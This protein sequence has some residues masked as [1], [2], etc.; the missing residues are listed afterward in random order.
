MGGQFHNGSLYQSIPLGHINTVPT[1]VRAFIK[2]NISALTGKTLQDATL[3]L[4]RNVSFDVAGPAVHQIGVKLVDYDAG[5]GA[6]AN[7]PSLIGRSVSVAG[8]VRISNE[9]SWFSVNVTEAVQAAIA[10]GYS[11]ITLR[12]NDDTADASSLAPAYVFLTTNPT[13]TVTEAPAIPVGNVATHIAWDYHAGGQ[14][15]NGAWNGVVPVGNINSMPTGVRAFVKFDI[16]AFAGRTLSAATLTLP[17]AA[18][19]AVTGTHNVGVSLVGHDAGGGVFANSPPW[20]TYGITAGTTVNVSNAATSYSLN[21]TPIIQE[22]INRGY[23]YA[24]IRLNDNTAEAGSAA[25]SY[26]FFATNPTLSLAEPAMTLVENGV[27]R[28][29]IHNMATGTPDIVEIYAATQLQAAI[30]CATGVTPAIN[31]PTPAPIKIN[32]GVATQFASGVGNANEQAYTYRR[33]GSNVVELVANKPAGVLWAVDDFSREILD[34]MWPLADDQITRGGSLQPTLKINPLTKVTWPDFPRRGWIIAD[35]TDG[36]H[37]NDL[38][39]NWMARTRQNV[40]FNPVSQLN[41][42]R[43][44]KL[45]HGI[46]P[47]T[48]MHSFWWLVPE[49]EYFDTHP[50]Y[51]P[52][53]GGVR[54]RPDSPS[55]LYVQLC[56]S[57]P[58]VLQI[59]VN[60]ALAS[61]AAFPEMQIFGVCQNDGSG[62]WC[63]C[64]NCQAWDG[65]QAGTGKYSNRLIHFVNLVAQGIATAYPDKKIGTYAYSESICPPTISVASNV[66]ITFTT[67]GRNYMKK[68]TDSSDVRNAEVMVNLNGWLAKASHVQFWEYFY[69]TG[70][71]RCAMPWARTL[72]EEYPDLLAL[73]V[74]GFCSE[75]YP[76]YWKGM[77]FFRYAF[78]RLSWDSSLTYEQLLTDFCFERYGSAAEYMEEFH[79]LY[80]DT[81]YAKV[82]V[83]TMLAPGEQLLPPAFTPLQMTELEGYLADAEAMSAISGTAYHQGQVAKERELFESFKKLFIDPETI[84]GIGA[85]LLTDPGAEAGGSSWGINTQSGTYTFPIAT[86]GAHTGAKSFQIHCTGVAGW[87]RWHQPVTGLIPGKKYAIK[88]WIKATPGASGEIWMIAKNVHIRIAFMESQGQWARVV[89]P[90][91]TVPADLSPVDVPRF[92]MNCFGA[93]DAYFDDLFLAKLPD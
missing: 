45:E 13:L 92:Y 69:Y 56:L 24:T 17:R 78:S 71:E 41:S 70:L 34:V 51:F 4:P 67:G 29:S 2:F 73:G 11:Y 38:V 61:F 49:S 10:R 57:N 6:F 40:I 55:S 46:E 42:A 50:E 91:F 63:Q 12:M 44:K 60:K 28:V 66:A 87:S 53:I 90:E 15:H 32:I 3:I 64:A 76:N 39:C 7:S 52:L 58:N 83:M 74:K 81:I 5:A 59:T 84:P 35:N 85:N 80:E 48:T 89:C 18:A 33:A 25:P 21:I 36:F 1:G 62:G 14:F 79:R 23:E 26:V 27:S 68:L 86:G 77:S 19:Y 9:G 16:S 54:K 8:S 22:A 75:T 82:P 93:G 43:I 47:D 65:P 31:P 88:A 37:Y 30:A 72:C 20:I